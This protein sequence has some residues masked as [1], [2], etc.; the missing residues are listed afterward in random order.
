MLPLPSSAVSL[1]RQLASVLKQL[2]PVVKTYLSPR[3][4]K[5]L[6]TRASADPGRERYRRASM[7]GHHVVHRKSSV[8]ADGLRLCAAYRWLS[9]CGEIRRLADHQ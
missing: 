7:T 5:S 9:R 3:G 2:I 1:S 8:H 6:F 4:F